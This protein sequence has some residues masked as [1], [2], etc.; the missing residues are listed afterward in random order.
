[1]STT[2][3]VELKET[4]GHL[5]LE[6]ATLLS[7]LDTEAQS[8]KWH[9]QRSN[10]AKCQKMDSMT[11]WRLICWLIMAAIIP[12]ATVYGMLVIGAQSVGI[13]FAVMAA[14]LLA[15]FEIVVILTLISKFYHLSKDCPSRVKFTETTDKVIAGVAGH[16][17]V[18]V[19]REPCFSCKGDGRS[20]RSPDDKC[21]SCHGYGVQFKVHV[22]AADYKHDVSDWP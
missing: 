6:R 20:P 9:Y 3:I 11:K 12:T 8:A 4:I 22:D 1:M 5:K 16:V 2:D 13:I 21:Y 7:A 17:P 19:K 15:T 10:N 14:I 18:S